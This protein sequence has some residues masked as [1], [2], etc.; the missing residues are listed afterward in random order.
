M[1][2]GPD[3]SANGGMY[4]YAQSTILSTAPSPNQISPSS[5]VSCEEQHSKGREVKGIQSVPSTSYRS[6]RKLA[7][8]THLVLLGLPLVHHVPVFLGAEF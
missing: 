6:T 2:V 8:G 5:P 3:P 4:W 1:T 7:Q